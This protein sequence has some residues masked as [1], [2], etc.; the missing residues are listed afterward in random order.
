M[1]FLTA[2][3]ILFVWMLATGERNPSRREWLSA[4]VL[5]FFIFVCDYGLLFWAEQRVPSGIA[6]VVL[7]T[8]PA[9]MALSE[10]FFLRTQT[11]TIRLGIAL[12]IVVYLMP[13]GRVCNSCTAR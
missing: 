13:S 12:L 6:A 1:R 2:G 7:A 5:G 9:F 4:S 8:I 11:F 3:I 10:I